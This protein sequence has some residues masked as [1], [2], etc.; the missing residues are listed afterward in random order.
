LHRLSIRAQATA[1][2]TAL[3][4]VTDGLSTGSTTLPAVNG[5]D[6]TIVGVSVATVV[7][8][9]RTGMGSTVLTNVLEGSE[10]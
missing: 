1:T 2:A 4:S 5:G 9:T 6:T 8:G 7:S 10:P 3:M